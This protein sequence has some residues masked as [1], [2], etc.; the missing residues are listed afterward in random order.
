ML[1]SDEQDCPS[2]DNE[3]VQ[4][5]PENSAVT[6][7]KLTV[8]HRN[9]SPQSG[10]PRIIQGDFSVVAMSMRNPLPRPQASLCPPI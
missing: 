1:L 6:G 4:A 9:H 3:A 7:V 5:G 8:M 2:G 10:T